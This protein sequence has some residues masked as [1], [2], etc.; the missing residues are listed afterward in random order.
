MEFEDRG[1]FYPIC[2]FVATAIEVR[3]RELQHE[4]GVSEGCFY[5]ITGLRECLGVH[6]ILKIVIISENMDR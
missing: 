3:E 2:V 1:G 4:L 6:Y 5:F